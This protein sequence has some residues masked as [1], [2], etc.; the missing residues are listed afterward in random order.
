MLQFWQFPFEAL[1]V[2]LQKLYLIGVLFHHFIGN[3]VLEFSRPCL[4]ELL[5]LGLSLIN[6]LVGPSS[7]PFLIF[8]APSL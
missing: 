3:E 6:F 7:L 4:S 2:S 8:P 1:I 5:H